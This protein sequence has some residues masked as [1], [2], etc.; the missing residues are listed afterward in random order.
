MKFQNLKQKRIFFIILAVF[1]LAGILF[2]TIKVIRIYRSGMRLV[3]DVRQAQDT[4]TFST[5]TEDIKTAG[6]ILEDIQTDLNDFRHEVDA[7]LWI[8]PL[9]KWVPKYGCDIAEAPHI[10]DLA[11]ALTNSGMESY[12]A[13]T[14]I[15][16]AF[17]SD[18]VDLNPTLVTEMLVQARPQF[19]SAR[20]AFE[21]AQIAREEI[22]TQC[23]SPY[24]HDILVN[25]IDPLLPLMR[26]GLTVA[27]EIPA[28]VGATS[29]GAKTY[30]LLIQNEDELRP[31]GGFITAAGTLV[32]ENG[33][34]V[35][36]DFNDSGSVDD[37]SKPYPV[38]PWQFQKYM[39]NS[40]LVFR[41]S[42][43]F[44]DF[45]K[46]ALYAEYLYTYTNDGAIDGVIAFD[47]QALV[48]I[49]GAVGTI[50]LESAPY[51]IDASNV[52]SYM[53][54][55]KTTEEQRLASPDLEYKVFIN[56][57]STALIDKLFNGNIELTRLSFAIVEA[58]NEH[59][60]LIKLNNDAIGMMAS[61]YDWDGRI[62]AGSGDFLM[63]VDSNIGY[64]KTNALVSTS[65]FYDIDLT[66][67]GS[68]ES[69]LT[70]I[71]KNDADSKV[72]CLQAHGF[73]LEGQKYYPVDRCYWNYMRIYTP[74]GTTLQDANLQAIP[75]DW[76][77]RRQSVP[78]QVD[79]LEEDIEGVQ[80]FGVLKVVPGGQ[81]RETSFQFELP[82]NIVKNQPDSGIFV[83]H[84]FIKKQPG[85]L[86]IP[87]T[88]RIH[89][90]NNATIQTTTPGAVI[91][92]NNVLIETDLREDRE[93]EITFRAP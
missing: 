25:K 47:Q 71:H 11:E 91:Q 27:V 48:K 76:M 55:A 68:P 1:L 43:W 9:M 41:D 61:Y 54:S 8:A 75:A 92:D 53:R 62:K 81:T 45:S 5:N 87:I 88:V 51:P 79:V 93:I 46:A 15:L 6:S 2:G 56:E 23:L 85:T 82:V 42:N 90:A 72:P 52:I 28:I 29:E 86:A 13:A 80:A 78:A 36:L 39:N 34:I 12:Q 17:D 26:D 20:D 32:L 59:H 77:I 18:E 89:F 30:L 37:W 73:T 83:Y 33:K 69:N 7:F 70:V 21:G 16:Q 66:D 49:L 50:S 22:D 31:T 84:L 38:A 10:L 14:P 3:E 67:Y 65:F 60:I 63:V 58:L 74:A 24:V 19:S 35:E 40:V 4:V 57:I 64:N 44:T